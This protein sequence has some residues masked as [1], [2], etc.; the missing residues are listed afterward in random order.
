MALNNTLL[1]EYR[2][3][4]SQSNLDAMENRWSE[5][6]AF[7]AYKEDTPN[8]IPGA[9]VI[10]NEYVPGRTVSVVVLNRQ[11]MSTGSTRVCTMTSTQA[12]S[13]YVTPSWTT[14]VTSFMMVPSQ[15]KGNYVKYQEAF[16]HL[17]SAVEYAFLAAL[18][19]AAYTSLDTN[20]STVNDADGNPYTVNATNGMIIPNADNELS[21]NEIPSVLAANDLPNS[22]IRC[23]S[24]QRLG[25]L[26]RELNAQ[27]P[28]NQANRAFQF[29]PFSFYHSNR[30]TVAAGD[31]D[32]AYFA[33][34]GSLAYLYHLNDDYVQNRKAGE[35]EWTTAQLPRLGQ[36]VEL[37]YVAACGD[38]SSLYGGT[39]ASS[40]YESFQWSFD[41]SF[42]TAYDSGSGQGTSIFQAC[43]SLT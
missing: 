13:T 7:M 32:N 35:T 3:S 33:P 17:L 1:D 42:L 9:D 15:H 18:D 26:V 10:Q 12:T 37:L 25:A 29:G 21:F 16:N 41:Y 34:F 40:M 20:K 43:Y 5:F 6:G 31:R 2:L 19:T 22:Q 27:G 8:L 30:V 36:P 24:S 14:I 28:G 4:R 11:T 23:I 39:T 38:K